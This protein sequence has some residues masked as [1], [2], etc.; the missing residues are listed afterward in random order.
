MNRF[1]AFWQSDGAPPDI[2]PILACGDELAKPAGARLRT[3]VRHNLAY[4]AASWSFPSTDSRQTEAIAF[5][6]ET[7]LLAD[8]RLDDRRSL[9][10]RL[11]RF[12]R[13][14]IRLETSDAQ[15]LLHAW[16]LWGE[17]MRQRV[18]GDYAFVVA[19]VR[20]RSLFAARSHPGWRPLFYAKSRAGVLVASGIDALA[21]HPKVSRSPCDAAVS[22]FLAF[23]DQGRGDPGRTALQDVRRVSSGGAVVF[24]AERREREL[25]PIWLWEHCASPDLSSNPREVP[26]QFFDLVKEAT[27]DRLWSPE[28][29]ILLS[30]G[31]DSSM[32]ACCAKELLDERGANGNLVAFTASQP[33][34]PLML[35]EEAAA[36]LVAVRLNVPCRLMEL[37]A[38]PFLRPDSRL[39]DLSVYPSGERMDA[40]QAMFS[41]AGPICLNGTMGDALRMRNVDVEIEK[42]GWPRFVVRSLEVWRQS[43]LWPNLG[44]LHRARG[45]TMPVSDV[46]ALPSWLKREKI[47]A[48][49][50]AEE[51]P[52]R[53][54]AHD[55]DPN[56]RLRDFRELSRHADSSDGYG[57]FVSGESPVEMCDP[58]GDARVLSF[59]AKLE[60]CPWRTHKFVMRQVL[61]DRLPADITL[62]P[63]TSGISQLSDFLL[64]SES[65]WVDGFVR[66]AGLS[67]WVD[68]NALPPSRTW[69]YDENLSLLHGRTLFLALWLRRFQ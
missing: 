5:D 43:G 26:G 50:L 9:A 42:L 35:D 53:F 22:A 33:E 48:H 65:D 54:L 45:G 61:K 44:L 15:M 13:C 7:V 1:A 56:R 34:H 67:E 39:P 17:S 16:R 10:A 46:D 37:R 62:R 51:L 28:A 3:G 8:A 2:E 24:D 55:T 25:P 68:F 12:L 36:R 20:T 19:D 21:C 11:S 57:G 14:D 41:A 6:N 27:R 69:G 4:V 23:R 31:I 40:F 47:D 30:G 49:G 18:L 29:S 63:K 59:A 32:I 58:F 64:T 38:H 52:R 66:E 60:G